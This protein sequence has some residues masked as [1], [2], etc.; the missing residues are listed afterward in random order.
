LT[1]SWLKEGVY[2]S[3]FSCRDYVAFRRDRDE[4]TSNKKD[5]GGVL[6]LLRKSSFNSILHQIS[7][8]NKSTE[9]IWITLNLGKKIVHLCAVYISP[10]TDIQRVK[11]LQKCIINIRTK[12]C[13]DDFLIVGDF[14]IP[15]YDNVTMG[16][17]NNSRES[18][19]KEMETFCN[20]SQLSSIKNCNNGILD[21]VFSNMYFNVHEAGS[22]LLLPVDKYHPPLSAS[23]NISTKHSKNPLIYFRNFKKINYKA[24]NF[25]LSKID[26][27]QILSVH[28]NVDEMVHCF[29]EKL[30]AVL[31]TVA[32]LIQKKN[33]NFPSWFSKNTIIMLKN[34]IVYHRKWKRYGNVR[35]KAFFNKLRESLKILISDDYGKW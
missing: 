18:I 25:I 15:N 17:N 35:D 16:F 22:P 30:E 27:Y 33:S 6:V 14:N 5:G 28:N 9:D 23:F 7:W 11:E 2:N 21:L 8:Q 1:E 31:N 3:E 20:F 32:P 12:H 26:W 13:N 10:S 24:L 29:Y 19:V 4:H 34:K